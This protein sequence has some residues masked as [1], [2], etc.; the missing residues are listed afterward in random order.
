[1]RKLK[2]SGVEIK[3]KSY[4]F[5]EN[6]LL[7]GRWDINFIVGVNKGSKETTGKCGRTQ[8]LKLWYRGWNRVKFSDHSRSGRQQENKRMVTGAERDSSQ[9]WTGRMEEP[10]SLRPTPKIVERGWH[11]YGCI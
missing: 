6:T 4:L 5:N 7:M 3:K 10:R 2:L 8:W 1:M 9:Q 11:G